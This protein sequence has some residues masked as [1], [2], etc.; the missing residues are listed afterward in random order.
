MSENDYSNVEFIDEAEQAF[1]HEARLGIEV[2][3]FV[4]S[5]VGRFLHG[6]AKLDVDEARDAIL[7]LDPYD[8]E[9]RK[10]ISKLRLKA[11]SGHAFLRWCVEAINNGRAAEQQL[12]EEYQR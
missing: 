2:T 9:D 10:E 1:F 3:S 8:A 6:R 7:E 12:T 4:N 5:E 11:A